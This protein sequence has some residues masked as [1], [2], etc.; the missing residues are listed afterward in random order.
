MSVSA[1]LFITS[2]LL[3]AVVSIIYASKGQVSRAYNYLFLS[4][5]GNGVLK[6][7]VLFV[8]I[9]LVVALLS[10]CSNV[11]YMNRGEVY[12]GLDSTFKQSP[13]CKSQK[14]KDFGDE[15]LT[16]NGGLRFNLMESIDKAWKLNLK[17]THHSCAF[18]SDRSG[19]DG[20]GFESVYTFWGR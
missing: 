12:I 8:G 6:G 20:I 15:K 10:G 1:L 18:S 13:Q 11:T 5:E 16:S 17:Y 9:G 14:Y 2:I 3:I 19:Y 4:K 7:I